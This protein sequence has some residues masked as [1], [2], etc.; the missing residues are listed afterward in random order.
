MHWKISQRWHT[1]VAFLLLVDID[2][3]SFYPCAHILI[4]NPTFGIDV[5]DIFPTKTLNYLIASF[6]WSVHEH[7]FLH[8]SETSCLR[9]V[10]KDSQLQ[11]K[12][13]GH[14][15]E[16]VITKLTTRQKIFIHCHGWSL[17]WRGTLICNYICDYIWDSHVL[18]NVPSMGG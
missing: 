5:H 16:N 6:Q 1:L 9:Q 7:A 11:K 13:H 15:V 12:W 14:E 3:N 10:L 18:P 17:V 4:Q 8:P 2:P